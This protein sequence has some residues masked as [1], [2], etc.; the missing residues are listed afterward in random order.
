MVGGRILQIKKRGGGGTNIRWEGHCIR[1]KESR[2]RRLALNR[3]TPHRGK[4]ENTKIK[5]KRHCRQGTDEVD[6]E[7]HE[8]QV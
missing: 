2:G 5:W 8:H 6:G 3:S 4:W 7:R 1:E